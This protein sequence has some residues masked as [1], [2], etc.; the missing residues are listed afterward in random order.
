[1]VVR[2]LLNVIGFKVDDD[3]Y[4]KAHQKTSD[5][6]GNIKKLFAAL[7][8]Y[9]I[10]KA[11]FEAAAAEEKLNAEFAVLLQSAEKATGFLDTLENMEQKGIVL[12]DK[13]SMAE[14]SREMMKFGMQAEQIPATLTM[15]GNI[16]GTSKEKLIG[17]SES[18]ARIQ[19]EGQL[20][21]RTM[22]QMRSQGGFD[23]LGEIARTSGKSVPQLQEMLKKGQISASMV[24]DAFHSAT[25][26]GGRFF[27]MTDK[28]TNTLAG[29]FHLMKM[30]FGKF[31]ET[32]GTPLIALATKIM[33]F[34]TSILTDPKI[35]AYLNKL[36]E[37]VGKVLDAIFN[38]AKKLMPVI[39]RV[40]DAIMP[41]L[42]PLINVL[43]TLFDPIVDIIES[44]IDLLLTL[45]QPLLD[46]LVPFITLLVSEL[47]PL[48]AIISF[49]IDIIGAKLKM[50]L[51][52]VR[53]LLDIIKVI[54][55]FFQKSFGSIFDKMGSGFRVIQ[56]ATKA[57]SVII[58]KLLAVLS[59]VFMSVLKAIF[60]IIGNFLQPAIDKLGETLSKVGQF[61]AD[62]AKDILTNALNAVNWLL[63]ALNKIIDTVNKVIPG[64]GKIKKIEPIKIGRAHV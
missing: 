28:L 14:A 45:A 60:Q 13:E 33:G 51:F 19:S 24:Y 12:I 59:G 52:P 35:N 41:I 46:M 17:L 22:M 8:I 11:I 5:F 15:F 36:M 34:I 9:E 43:L 61:L 16:A 58:D 57:I 27:G 6:V 54:Y 55:D 26:E 44:V 53:L 21:S 40:L 47:K 18:F 3:Q 42:E 25:S 1:M 37:I 64:G 10:G 32:A 39:M 31:V 49:L 63:E 23:I 56:N 62:I 2:E 50:W 4:K 38:A 48:L 7:A 30:A 20:T 29:Q